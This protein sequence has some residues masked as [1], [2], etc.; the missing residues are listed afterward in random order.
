MSILRRLGRA[1]ALA[2]ILIPFL[3]LSADAAT[4][5][6]RSSS[7]A[8]VSSRAAGKSSVHKASA[9]K[10]SLA[11]AKAAAPVVASAGDEEGEEDANAVTRPVRTAAKVP[12]GVSRD[13]YI[14]AIS[15]DADTGRVFQ[16]DRADQAG[17]PASITKL[18]TMLLVLEDVKAGKYAL[19]D[20]ATASA[21]ATRQEPSSVG[22]KAGQSMTIDDL[23]YSIMIKSANDAAV[24]LAEKSAGSV[25]AFVARMN[26]KA[27]ALGMASTK[28]VSPNGLP[29]PRGSKRGFDITTAADLVKLAREIV[30][31][32]AALKY[33]REATH[34]VTDGAGKPLMFTNH[35]LFLVHRKMKIAGCDGLKTG[36]TAAAGS[37]IVL[38]AARHGRRVIVVVLGSSHRES[39]DDEAARLMADAW[40]A[41]DCWRPAP[42]LRSSSSDDDASASPAAASA[43][44]SA[45]AAGAAPVTAVETTSATDVPRAGGPAPAA[46]TPVN[47]AASN[48]V[49]AAAATNIDADVPVVLPEEPSTGGAEAADGSEEK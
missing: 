23:L 48:S 8:A 4:R 2:A 43:P 34:T 39:R 46:L 45:S 26:E 32:P 33:T 7:R 1:L 41:L 9:R 21:L 29:P 49:P 19:T 44:A 28:F 27:A 22:I 42:A 20:H 5:K 13:P 3:S 18:M 12:G 14:G 24:V 35:N 10:S 31:H 16:S 6:G 25:D 15:V 38:T 11:A 30:R 47:A 17:Y 37:S 36:Y 40:G